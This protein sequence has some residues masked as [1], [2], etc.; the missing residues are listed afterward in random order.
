MR[1]IRTL[2]TAL[3]TASL[4]RGGC[5]VAAG[6]SAPEQ[7]VAVATSDLQTKSITLKN[8]AA[9][10]IDS[11]PD[12]LTVTVPVRNAKAKVV[13]SELAD[14]T[15]TVNKA[16]S[17]KKK[18]VFQIEIEYELD[19]GWDGCTFEFTGPGYKSTLEAGVF[20]DD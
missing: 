4:A 8:G 10:T 3:I 2:H 17:T 1:L 12:A 19:G 13:E 14:C 20:I 7:N 6:D 11:E 9:R 15:I 18:T 16:R 5:A